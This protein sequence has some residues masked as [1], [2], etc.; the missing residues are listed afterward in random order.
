MNPTK[1]TPVMFVL[2]NDVPA[3]G[4]FFR[5]HYECNI[6]RKKSENFESIFPNCMKI[7]NL[8]KQQ[9]EFLIP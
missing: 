4:E 7:M 3:K 2:L 1:L 9:S 5:D 8:F 6:I